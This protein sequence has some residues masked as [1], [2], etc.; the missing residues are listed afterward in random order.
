MSTPS[1]S[2]IV[3]TRNRPGQLARCLA[4]L[5]AL[6]YPRERYEVVVVDD[7]GNTDTHGI[8]SKIDQELRTTCV[9]V[10]HGG[11]AAARNAGVAASGGEIIA[12]TDDDCAVDPEWLRRLAARFSAMR[13]SVV[14][15]RVMN[16]LA[17]NRYSSA[18]Q[19]LQD[20]LYRWYHEER[21]GEL[22]FF[23]TNNLALSRFD[24]DGIGGFDETFTF[25]SEDRDLSDRA[26]A[27][28]LSLVYAPDA[29][30][31]H[32]HELGL[33]E[34]LR[35]HYQ[36][37][38]GAVHFRSRRRARRRTRVRLEP[39]AFYYEMLASPFKAGSAEPLVGSLLLLASQSA[40]LAGAVTRAA[41]LAL[42]NG[43]A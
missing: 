5:A 4:S 40:L 8:V 15:G 6:D 3:P 17:S 18:S 22:R 43:R 13:G 42:E 16:G 36:Y 12:F 20:F 26:L 19:S 39:P 28:G 35:Q 31:H 23:T 37:G 30:V 41:T 7:G 21:G 29:I 27:A 32:A 10:S 25:A 34:F 11:P 38:K 14:G 1:F 33:G 2:V 9:R 24:F